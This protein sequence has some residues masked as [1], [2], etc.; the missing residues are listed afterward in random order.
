MTCSFAAA[1]QEAE[2]DAVGSAIDDA[3]TGVRR[4][5]LLESAGNG[6]FSR[7]LELVFP[8]DDYRLGK[9]RPQARK[10][11]LGRAQDEPQSR[12]AAWNLSLAIAPFDFVH[13][14]I[15]QCRGVK[16]GC[17]LHGKPFEQCQQRGVC[18]EGHHVHILGLR[19]N[20]HFAA[21]TKHL[22]VGAR[23]GLG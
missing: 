5:Y 10:Q 8:P 12:N 7:A 1:R 17:W 15:T 13:Q 11:L 18:R 21:K 3:G 16:H 19:V 9:Q 23:Q 2:A 4:V 20:S 22:K 6:L 14:E